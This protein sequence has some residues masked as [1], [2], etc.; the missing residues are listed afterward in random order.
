[1]SKRII[2]DAEELNVMPVGSIIADF[3]KDDSLLDCPVIAC[4]LPFGAWQV[5]GNTRRWSSKEV[6]AGA[7]GVPLTVLHN[8]KA[9]R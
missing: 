6:I 9:P 7:G 5:M 4:K 2:S 1:M 3:G 8:P